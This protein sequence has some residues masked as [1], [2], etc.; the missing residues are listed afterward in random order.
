[1]I[2]IS[3]M[4]YLFRRRRESGDPGATIEALHQRT[5]DRSD[6]ECVALDPRFRGGDGKVVGFLNL[7]SSQPLRSTRRGASRRTQAGPIVLYL[8]PAYVLETRRSRS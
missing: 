7:I 1:M 2:Q 5:C 4:V 8:E 6:P 3:S